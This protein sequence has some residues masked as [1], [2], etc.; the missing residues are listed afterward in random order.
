MF[1]KIKEIKIHIL[2]I[3]FALGFFLGINISELKSAE[4]SAFK[5]LEYFHFVYNTIT[6]EYVETTTPRQ[7]LEGAMSGL[8]KS[9]NDPYSRFLD[10]NNLNQ[11]KEAVTGEFVGI[12]IEVTTKDNNIVVVSPIDDS[13]AQKAGI[14]SGDIIIQINDIAVQPDNFADALKEIKGKPDTELKLKIVR[15]GFSEPVDYK[16]KRSPIQIKSIKYGILKESP[17]T[18]YLKLAH[19]YASSPNEMEKAIKFVNSSGIKKL[20]LDLRSNPGGDMIAA[21]EIADMFLEKGKTIVTTKGKDQKTEIEKFVSKQDPV[22]TGKMLVLV[23]EGSASS[24]EILSGA[25]KD[26]QRCKLLGE[27]TFGKALVQRVITVEEGK[28]AFTLTINKYYT[29]SGSM[30]HKKGIEPDITVVSNTIPEN[31]RKNL[32]RIINDNLIGDYAKTNKSYNKYNV[33]QLLE[34]LKEK[35]LPIS[36]NVAAYFYKLELNRDKPSDLYDLEF[37]NQLNEAIKKINE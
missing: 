32:G 20:I 22:Y 2:V 29:P 10:E 4:N 25:L 19:F 24:S 27:K 15:N 1:K 35:N 16:I 30:I 13:P 6:N 36:E 33:M 34:T 14:M 18:A 7:L 3:I 26:N 9:L 8:L 17:D 11:F 5:Y 12:G 23:N 21:V 28:S 37:D 31:D